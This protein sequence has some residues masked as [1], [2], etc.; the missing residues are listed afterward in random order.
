MGM[1]S[2]DIGVA[3]M[4]CD[5]ADK[6]NQTAENIMASLVKQLSLRK[7]STLDHIQKLYEQCDRGKARPGVTKLTET[8]KNL[9]TVYRRIYVVI[10]ALDECDDE[11][12]EL[13]LAQ[14]EK[15]DHSIVR[16]FLTSRPHLIEMQRKFDEFPQV[17]IMAKDSDIR[18][19]IQNSIREK[20]NLLE[21][22]E[23]TAQLEEKI[24]IAITSRAKG[25]QVTFTL[26]P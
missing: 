9:C 3:Y 8:L 12:R 21:L 11:S 16:I 13:L 5:Y 24:V 7:P 6:D 22:I 20:A 2:E 26:L 19:F 18:V 23:D 17:E 1:D 4:Y 14:L 25:M 10:D 15:V